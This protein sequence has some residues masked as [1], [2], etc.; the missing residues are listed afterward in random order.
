M[1]DL[2]QFS[3]LFRVVSTCHFFYLCPCDLII[4]YLALQLLFM[5]KLLAE[6]MGHDFI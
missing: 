1:I 4:F 6:V 2:V 5:G 3:Y